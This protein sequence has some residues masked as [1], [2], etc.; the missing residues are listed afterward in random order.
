[1]RPTPCFVSHEPSHPAV[2]SPHEPQQGT[3]AHVKVVNLLALSPGLRR[4]LVTLQPCRG[5]S[6]YMRVK[7]YWPICH[8]AILHQ[9]LVRYKASQVA[10]PPRRI[11]IL[12]HWLF[13]S[14]NSEWLILILAVFICGICNVWTRT[15]PGAWWSE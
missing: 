9:Q 7:L 3:L 4:G 12:V 2:V 11:R 6:F 8:R 1:V 10:C 14:A 13:T 15:A 5:I